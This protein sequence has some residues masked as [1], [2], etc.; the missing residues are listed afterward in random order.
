MTT[1]ITLWAAFVLAT[2]IIAWF[3]TRRQAMAFLVVAIATAAIPMATL[4]QPSR[5]LPAGKHTVLGARI[6]KDVTIYVLLDAQPEPRYYRL[7]YTDQAA[8]ALQKAMDGTAG[9]EGRVTMQMAEGDVAFAE[10]T[11]PAEPEKQAEQPV[12]GG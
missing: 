9:G 4:G 5:S 8:N 10:E 11:P 2:G 3:G 7:P 6:D 1:A 12:I